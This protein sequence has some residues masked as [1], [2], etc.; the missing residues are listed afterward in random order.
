M[1][2]CCDILYL[3]VRSPRTGGLIESDRDCNAIQS[4]E[5]PKTGVITRSCAATVPQLYRHEQKQE[6]PGSASGLCNPS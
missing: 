4:E 3:S 6:S 2:P 1:K 5:R